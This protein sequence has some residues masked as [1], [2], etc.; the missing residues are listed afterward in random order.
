[1]NTGKYTGIYVAK[2]LFQVNKYNPGIGYFS[3][4]VIMDSSSSTYTEST[5]NN[6]TTG[7]ASKDKSLGISNTTTVNAVKIAIPQEI[8]W[9][10]PTKIVPVGTVFFVAFV[11]GDINKPIIVGRDINGYVAT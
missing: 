9:F 1:M 2:L 3:I 8:T 10:Y 5:I 4:P 11:G 6:D 7:I